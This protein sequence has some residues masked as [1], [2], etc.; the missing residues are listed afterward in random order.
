M[1]LLFYTF[2]NMPQGC[3]SSFSL[4]KLLKSMSYIFPPNPFLVIWEAQRYSSLFLVEGDTLK[5]S[6]LSS[7][8]LFQREE[9]SGCRQSL[10]T[11]ARVSAR[12][13]LAHSSS[14][15]PSQIALSVSSK[16]LLHLFPSVQLSR[17]SSCLLSLSLFHLK[18]NLFLSVRGRWE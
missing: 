1:R 14:L 18:S 17:S 12:V 3:H 7:S 4:D 5:M 6:K 15:T 9:A 13:S 10:L 11:T 16:H 8:I 2:F